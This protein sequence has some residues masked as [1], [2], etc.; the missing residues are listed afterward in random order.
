MAYPVLIIGKSGSGK[1]ASLRNLNPADVAVINVLGKP[2]PFKSAGFRCYRTDDYDKVK[3]AISKTKAPIIVIDD[4]GYLITNSFMRGH[5]Q[6]GAGNSL[7]TF[8]NTIGDRYWNFIEFISL[9]NT[10]QRVYVMMHEDTNDFGSVKPKTIGKLLDEKVC[11][12]GMFTMCLRCMM[13]NG[14]HVFHTQSD[15]N[16]VAKTPIGMFDTLTIDNDLALVDKSIC[17]YY[18]IKSE[19][20]KS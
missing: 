3:A 11:V 9:L 17:E 6:S 16:D 7:Y 19:G 15:G 2:L 18:E 20:D 14:Q 10:D 5:A 1:S 4:A 12:E 13:E 8:Y